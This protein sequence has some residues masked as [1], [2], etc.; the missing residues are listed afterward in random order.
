MR[1]HG[2]D[3]YELSRGDKTGIG[4]L[5]PKS[6]QRTTDSIS[7][8]AGFRSNYHTSSLIDDSVVIRTDGSVTTDWTAAG[9]AGD[10]FYATPDWKSVTW[11]SIGTGFSLPAQA[12]QQNPVG[13]Y[14]AFE[15]YDHW[16]RYHT[17]R[18]DVTVNNALHAAF[19]LS[20]LEQP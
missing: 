11:L 12:I 8:S 17:G 4:I 19:V 5:Y 2:L 7:G 18:T 13:P 9:A 20:T 15:Y 3:Y 1:L 16:G 14:L 10:A 6:L